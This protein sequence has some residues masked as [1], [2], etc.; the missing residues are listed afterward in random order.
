MKKSPRLVISLE[1]QTLQVWQFG[2]CVREFPVSTSSRG[3]GFEKDSYRTP[4]GRFR[5]SEKIGA[6]ER[7]GTIFKCRLPVGF[8]QP[9]EATDDDL[10]LTR[11]LRLDGL[12][13]A[14]CNTLERCIY[15]HGTNCE[16]TLGQPASHGCVRMGNADVMELF[17]MV[18]VEDVVEIYPKF[19]LARI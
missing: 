4:T 17:D 7:S 5:I 18:D 8:W 14:N 13:E 1:S 2:I 15:I 3:E 6:G 9:H 11:I 16:D 12:D 19:R 10:I